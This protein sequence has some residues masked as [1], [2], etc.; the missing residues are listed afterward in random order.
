MRVLHINCNYIYSSLHQN[1]ISG[2]E[3]NGINNYVIV[4]VFFDDNRRIKEQRGVHVL[5][6]FHKWDRVWFDYK[7]KKI[8]SAI[9]QDTTE[10]NFDCI[11][12]HTLFTDGNCAMRLSKEYGI[13]YVVA[14]R[15]TD[16]NDF[17]KMMVHLRRRGLE[18]MRNASAIVF[19][20][21]AYKNSVI[22]KYVPFAEKQI[23]LNKSIVIPNGIDSYWLDNLKNK[24]VTDVVER[25]NQQEIRLIYAGEIDSNKNIEHTAKTK[26]LLEEKGWNVLFT[27]VGKVKEKAI[28]DRLKQQKNIMLLPPKKKEELILDY[29]KSDIFVMPSHKETFGLVY[30]EAL[31]QGLPVIYTK[32]QGFDGQFEEGFVGYAVDDKNEN[33]LKDVILKICDR[34]AEISNNCCNAAIKFRWDTICKT[35]VQTYEAVLDKK[36]YDRV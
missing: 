7:Q 14:V 23:M 25:I 10:M 34:Y 26:H 12:A 32:G 24:N 31:S 35:Y 29:R 3:K 13:P 21:E 18:I 4:P 19:L 27:V 30:A 36:Q 16:V 1:M 11:H 6:C 17:F 28:A 22:D 5:Q 33:D 20:S 8:Y 2:L 15:N 9:K